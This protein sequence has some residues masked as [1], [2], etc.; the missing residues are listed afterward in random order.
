MLKYYFIFQWNLNFLK[1]WIFLKLYL[2]PKHSFHL[3]LGTWRFH[4]ATPGY[5]HS[6]GG[7]RIFLRRG[8]GAPLRNG[9]TDWWCNSKW[10]VQFSC[11]TE[12]ST[13]RSQAKSTGYPWI[14]YVAVM[15]TEL[16]LWP[17]ERILC[18]T[19]NL[20]HLT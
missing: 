11:E 10:H 17:I 5:C 4:P 9:I 3:M 6:R 19:T 1:P 12:G 15:H 20:R 7:S 14:W 2:L 18:Q 13:H 8:L 16:L